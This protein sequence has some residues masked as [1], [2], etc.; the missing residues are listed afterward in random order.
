M[1]TNLQRAQDFALNSWLTE[2]PEDQTYEWIIEAMRKDTW[3]KIDVVWEELISPWYL[4]EDHSGEQ[5]AQ[6]IEDT[7]AQAL[8]L[9]DAT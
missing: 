4:V 6:F 5:I 1:K 9:L 2:Y 8:R 3:N 7:C